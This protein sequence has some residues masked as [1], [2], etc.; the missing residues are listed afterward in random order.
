MHREIEAVIRRLPSKLGQGQM[1][2]MQTSIIPSK[3]I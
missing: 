3:K 1:V 2:F